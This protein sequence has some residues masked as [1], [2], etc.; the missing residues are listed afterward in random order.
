MVSNRSDFEPGD[1]LPPELVETW[2]SLLAKLKEFEILLSLRRTILPARERLG[3]L[4]CQAPHIP[5]SG[6]ATRAVVLSKSTRPMDFMTTWVVDPLVRR[7]G[8][9]YD[10]TDFSAI[11]SYLGRSGSDD[12]DS[13]YRSVF[14]FQRWVNQVAR[15]LR[16][17][18][19][20]YLGDGA[21]Y[22]GRHPSRLLRLAL[23][24]QRYYER[25]LREGF[26]FDRGMRI[27]LNYG[28]YRLLPIEEGG[29]G[30]ARRYEFFG[31]GIVELTRLATGKSMRE[32]DEIKNLLIGLGYPAS[33]VETFFAPAL[34]QNVDLVDKAEESR[35]FYS[36]INPNG[37]LVNEGIVATQQFISEIER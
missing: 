26:P 24:L 18:L 27:A 22:S 5:G 12:Q 19:E 28:E 2:E 15:S 37:T 32:I 9:I 14:R 7:C 10:I 34:R 23:E 25:A 4:S 35:R 30:T 6:I 33:E 36:Y 21:L 1:L 29:F 11:V 13:S 17:Q 3:T 31:H 8:L 16:L 20:K